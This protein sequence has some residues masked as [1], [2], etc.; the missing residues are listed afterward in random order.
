MSRSYAFERASGRE[1]PTI[2]RD[3]FG[4]RFA[5]RSCCRSIAQFAV[6]QVARKQGDM[7]TH[8]GFQALRP[9][10]TLLLASLLLAV[11]ALVSARSVPL[12]AGV[13]GLVVLPYILLPWRDRSWIVLLAQAIAFC[14]ILSIATY[15]LQSLGCWVISHANWN[16]GASLTPNC[17]RA[18][19]LTTGLM[20]FFTSS[21][22]GVL[23]LVVVY[24]RSR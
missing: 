12:A 21:L 5:N 1:T 8:F 17:G 19:S 6:Y 2:R 9:L 23:Q 13:L 14:L 7:R 15:F 22:A 3:R 18:S 16:N 24:F 4:R 11:L 10:L 20:T